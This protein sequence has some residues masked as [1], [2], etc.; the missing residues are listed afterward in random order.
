A[1][2]LI[3]GFVKDDILH[4]L[5]KLLSRLEPEQL[6]PDP[7]E[8][9]MKVHIPYVEIDRQNDLDVVMDLVLAGPT[10]LVVEGMSE[11]IMIDARTYPVRGP[12]EPD[13]ER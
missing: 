7:L 3:D 4:Y 1:M 6:D 9:L 13:L 8:K 5:M 2:F 10:A 11:I 12:Q